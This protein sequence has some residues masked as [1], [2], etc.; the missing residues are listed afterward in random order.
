MFCSD[1]KVFR[2]ELLTEAMFYQLQGMMTCL[3]GELS[4]KSVILKH[5]DHLLIVASW[6][7]CGSTFSLLFRAS[8]DG[9]SRDDFHRC[10]DNR[11]PTLVVAKS[12]K[13][14]FGGFTSKP[15]DSREFTFFKRLK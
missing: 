4:G 7:P 6:L 1:D 10:C 11:G 14:I 3:G 13:Y 15:W 9:D 8:G 2:N 5:A 12:E